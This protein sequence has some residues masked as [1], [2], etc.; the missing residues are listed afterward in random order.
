MPLWDHQLW[1]T[2]AVPFQWHVHDASPCRRELFLA[3]WAAWE[4]RQLSRV[5]RQLDSGEIGLILIFL[6]LL[7]FFSSRM[8]CF[9]AVGKLDYLAHELL[10]PLPASLWD[11]PF[12]VCS[13]HILK[14]KKCGRNMF[15]QVFFLN[16]LFSE[17]AMFKG[18]TVIGVKCRW[19]VFNAEYWVFKSFFISTWDSNTALRKRI[20][21]WITGNLFGSI[22]DFHFR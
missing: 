6:S 22:K 10:S 14:V 9:F 7:C 8:H 18:C 3:L 20:L 21:K 17:D 5:P 12:S 2:Y 11:C 4:M 16:S 19:W 1:H 15:F 13:C